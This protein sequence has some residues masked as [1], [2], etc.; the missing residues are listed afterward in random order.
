MTMGVHAPAR[1]APDEPVPKVEYRLSP[2]GQSLLGPMASLID[3]AD[4]RYSDIH[5]ARARFDSAPGDAAR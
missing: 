5:A 3:W 2:L 1:R 4:T